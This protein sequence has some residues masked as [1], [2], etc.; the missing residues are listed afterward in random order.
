[1]KPIL[2]RLLSRVQKCPLSGCWLWTGAVNPKGYG[3]LRFN[4]KDL[5]ASRASWT[6]HRGPVPD[7]LLVLH[8]CDVPLCINPDHLFLGTHRDNV[9]DMDAKGRRVVVV[10]RGESNCKAKLDVHQVRRLREE[11]ACGASKSALSRKYGV[12]R[13]AIKHAVEG[14]TWS[15][16][17]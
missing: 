14:V 15:H 5:I 10:Q 4:R 6:A 9:A 13:Q 8:R 2:S 17:Q 16:V 3:H 11:F 12:N 1:M 7:G